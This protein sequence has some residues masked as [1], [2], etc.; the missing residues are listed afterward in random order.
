VSAVL[1][2]AKVEDDS[3]IHL[4]IADPHTG[5][6]LIA[7]LPALGCTAGATQHARLL[8]QRARVA[9]LKACGD[10]G[11]GDFAEY[12]HRSRATVTGVGFFDFFHGQRGVAPNEIE[13]HP[14]VSFSG[15][16][17]AR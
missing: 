13:L 12:R 5:G 6:T 7:E 11:A 10:P 16:C 1:I 17:G 8:M 4:V 14:V 3:D 2:A 15:H 9:F